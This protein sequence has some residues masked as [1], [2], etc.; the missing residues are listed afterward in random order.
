MLIGA[1]Q[2]IAGGYEKALERITAIGGNCLQIFSASPRSW[3]FVKLSEEAS[4]TWYSAQKRL[5]IHPVYF[6]ASYLINLAF[7]GKLGQL[8]RNNLIHELNIASRLEIKGSI[9]HLGSFKNDI[10]TT[11]NNERGESHK[12]LVNNISEILEKTPD[13]TVFIIENAAT[14][15]IGKNLQEISHII[16]TVSSDRL[17]VCLDTC[18]LFC[19]GYKISSEEE[20]NQFLDIFDDLIGIKRLEVIHTNDSKD[21]FGSGRDRHENI[22]IGTLGLETFQLLL[23]HPNL[24][25][26]PFIIETP[27]FDDKGP[28]KKNLDIL[29]NLLS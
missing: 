24:K 20:L 28:D 29:K 5:S 23:N 15:K 7:D 16:K 17:K 8:S 26:V 3:N 14:N 19:A 9:V 27:G 18:H 25:H 4:N 21:P 2:S 6:H 10:P 13:S 12:I 11:A 22:G 1:H